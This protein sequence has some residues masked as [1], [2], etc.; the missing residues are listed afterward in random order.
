MSSFITNFMHAPIFTGYVVPHRCMVKRNLIKYITLLS[1]LLPIWKYTQQ[2]HSNSL[3]NVRS[4]IFPLKVPTPS[5]L[6]KILLKS[7]ATSTILPSTHFIVSVAH[8]KT[9]SCHW[10]S[11]KPMPSITP[12]CIFIRKSLIHCHFS[13]ALDLFENWIVFLFLGC[14]LFS[15]CVTIA[16]KKNLK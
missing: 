10:F 5:F 15:L 11:T 4:L 8:V 12:I 14:L 13:V 2:I 6:I 3:H 9:I 16:I 7:S 1:Y